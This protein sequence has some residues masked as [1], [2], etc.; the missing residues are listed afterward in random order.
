MEI[1]KGLSGMIKRRK[2]KFIY[3]LLP[4]LLLVACKSAMQP[5]PGDPAISQI[6][7][8]IDEGIAS[9]TSPEYTLPPSLSQAMLPTR[10]V[11]ADAPK[12]AIN[13]RFD[14]T[15]T[16][17]GARTFFLSLVKDTPYNIIVSPEVEGS[18]SLDLKNVTVKEVL[19]TVRTVYGY[20]YTETPTGFQVFA[21]GVQTRIFT[22]NY[23][24]VE[25]TSSSEI[26]ISS[27]QITQ[28]YQGDGDGSSSSGS[29]STSSTSSTSNNS[30]S[31]GFLNVTPSAKISTK[32]TSNF[33]K[34]LEASL[35]SIVGEGA[36]RQVIINP[37]A[38]IVIVRATTLEL[39]Q[40]AKYL[41]SLENTMSR[42]VLL[43][44]KIIEV[45]LFDAYQAGIDWSLSDLSQTGT[46]NIVV[47]GLSSIANNPLDNFTNIFKLDTK[48]GTFSTVIELLSAQGNVQ[49]LSSPRIATLNNQ[50][51]VIKVGFDEFFITNVS[52]T[53]TVT[54]GF[55]GENTQDIELT[56]FFSGIALDVT[57]RI[58]ADGNVILHIHPIVSEVF[59]Q[60]KS[61]TVGGQ[62][63]SLPLALSV[64]RESDSMVE[65]RNGQVVII[66]G[67]MEDRTEEY[68]ASTPFARRIP[69]FG[70]FF[71]KTNQRSK[72][73]E[74]VILLRPT[75]V[76]RNSWVTKLEETRTSIQARDRG[77][78]FGDFPNRFGNLQ[79]FEYAEDFAYVP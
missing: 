29:S 27:G 64:I 25:R 24:D 72:K 65:A 44:A 52:N 45:Q 62:E 36:G 57:P 59:D 14:L 40:I 21:G 79:E 31:S 38:G 32:Q 22:V 26:S 5:N 48:A 37:Q 2:H 13:Q 46:Q 47:P 11:G 53:N 12:D 78:Y 16:D 54:G 71:R 19:D 1:F 55:A 50:K 56:P 51:A 60:E 43:E 33:W 3:G 42:Q 67:L 74:L 18:V 9:D 66:G 41:D 58:N 49:V 20:D 75:V 8:T 69:F 10:S 34:G 15:V 7:A 17:V 76:E 70:T 68:I 4:L 28:N 6:Y 30:S 23:I 35:T 63:Q 77:Y 39:D 73:T 61:F